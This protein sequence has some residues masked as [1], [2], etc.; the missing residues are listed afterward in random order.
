MWTRGGFQLGFFFSSSF[1]VLMGRIGAARIAFASCEIWVSEFTFRRYRS[2]SFGHFFFNH[3]EDDRL[4]F[5][6]LIE[7]KLCL[8][9]PFLFI[10]YLFG[11]EWRSCNLYTG[12]L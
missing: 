11:E 6:E 8:N 12:S 10:L 1:L 2:M 5:F 7:G 9:Y 3:E 4:G